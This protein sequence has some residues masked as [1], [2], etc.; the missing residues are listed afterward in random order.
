MCKKPKP[1]SETNLFKYA[2]K[3]LSQDAIICW[4]ISWINQPQSL[5]YPLAKE[6][7]IKVSNLNEIN[8]ATIY[9]QFKNIDVLLLINED[10]DDR[11][12]VIIEDKTFTGEHDNQIKRYTETITN[13]DEF[14][15]YPDKKIRTVFFKTGEYYPHD[16]KTV[17]N[18][19]N[20]NYNLTRLDVMQLIK[21]YIGNSQLLKDYYDY[22]KWLSDW[23]KEYES[24]YKKGDFLS[25]FQES[26]GMLICVKDL[27]STNGVWDHRLSPFEDLEV[28]PEFSN[29][30][31]GKSYS[32]VW[33]WGNNT[34]EDIKNHH[35]K[36]WLGFRLDHDTKGYFISLR[37]Y[38]YYKS[39]SNAAELLEKKTAMYN[40]LHEALD[41]KEIKDE[42]ETKGLYIIGKMPQEAQNDSDQVYFVLSPD[43]AA[44]N[45]SELGKVYFTYSK[46]HFYPETIDDEKIN[47]PI[48][49][50]ILK[51]TLM[52]LARAIMQS[53]PIDE[54]LT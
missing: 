35:N 1:L 47:L 39:Q 28:I 13:A 43:K 21:G 45:E 24:Y 46:K 22:L 15:K 12:F 52:P 50:E 2:T 30:N 38:H 18:K 11:L 36:Y 8:T 25:A 4:I 54:Y 27:F 19:K 32:W 40:S 7:I 14:R 16:E 20:C 17:S 34:E 42:F 44:Q 5:L 33:I 26:Y 48:N 3:E 49:K 10:K 41:S 31:G 9:K 51:A 53:F 6:F 23:Y 37:Q 29:S